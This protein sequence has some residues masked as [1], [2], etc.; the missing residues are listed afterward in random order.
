MFWFGKSRKQQDSL[1]Q[2]VEA[3]KRTVKER[4]HKIQELLEELNAE[5]AKADWPATG[6]FV[7]YK[8]DGQEYMV[9]NQTV[10]FLS[11][12]S[13]SVTVFHLED[14]AGRQK[15]VHHIELMRKP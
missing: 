10:A 8:P 4:D 12:W 7:I 13:P 3:L 15:E 2:E 14:S 5:P 6:D 11:H 1:L 9:V